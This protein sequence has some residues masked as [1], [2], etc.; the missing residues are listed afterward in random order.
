MN[1]RRCRL[2]GIFSDATALPGHRPVHETVEMSVAVYNGEN[3]T[4]SRGLSISGINFVVV[5]RGRAR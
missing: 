2:E 4:K 1:K 5:R 3:V